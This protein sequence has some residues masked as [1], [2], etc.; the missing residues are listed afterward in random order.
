MRDHK[1]ELLAALRTEASACPDCGCAIGWRSGDRVICAD[2]YPKPEGA[3]KVVV[4]DQLERR[5]WNCNDVEYSAQ[6]TRRMAQDE[7][8]GQ[9]T[10]KDTGA[11]SMHQNSF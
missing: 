2:C 5:E 8:K 6:R 7:R 10:T 1:D 9:A 4:V 11:V 3:E